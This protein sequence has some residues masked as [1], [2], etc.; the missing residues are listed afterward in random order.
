M[1]KNLSIAILLFVVFWLAAVVV[2]LETFHYAS[3]VGMCSELKP[4]DSLQTVKRHNC[5]HSKETRINPLWHLFYAL[6][7][8]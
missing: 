1:A 2:R 8:D 7:G 5:F 3:V 6:S 4:D